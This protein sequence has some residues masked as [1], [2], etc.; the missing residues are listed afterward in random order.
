VPWARGGASD[1]ANGLLL[2]RHHHRQVHEGG[3]TIDAAHP[4]RGAN[5]TLTFHGP[6]GQ[7]LTS[8]VP[9]ARAGPSP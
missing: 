1:L 9:A 2:C 4:A 3:W 6:D 8:T 5:G 7:T